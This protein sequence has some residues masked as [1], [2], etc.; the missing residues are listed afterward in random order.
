LFFIRYGIAVVN[1]LNRLLDI[2]YQRMQVIWV[3]EIKD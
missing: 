3:W 2:L 1:C